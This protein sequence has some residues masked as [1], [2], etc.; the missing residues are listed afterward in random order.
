MYTLS[1]RLINL[2]RFQ[3]ITKFQTALENEAISILI[4]KSLYVFLLSKYN[5]AFKSYRSFD[6]NEYA[7]LTKNVN[8][9]KFFRTKK[10][11]RMHINFL[12]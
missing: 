1:I 3:E 4:L 2:T 10:N 7:L 5:D 6:V 8:N 12:A 11:T 9:F